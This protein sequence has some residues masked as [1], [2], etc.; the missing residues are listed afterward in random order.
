MPCKIENGPFT[1]EVLCD[2]MPMD[3]CHI[4]LG[5]PWQFDRY[6]VYDGRVNK[7]TSL[8][9]GVTY[10]LLPLIET[11]EEMSCTVRACMVSGKEF[12]KDMKKNLNNFA[13]VPK[14]PNCSNDDQLSAKI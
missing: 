1:D 3:C 10:A 5:R 9:D 14:G 11:P 2:I 4:L 6:V 13:I 7:Y 12:E 8:K